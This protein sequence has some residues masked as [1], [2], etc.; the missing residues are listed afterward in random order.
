MWNTK[1][2][3]TVKGLAICCKFETINLSKTDKVLFTNAVS[4][5]K[6]AMSLPNSA[7]SFFQFHAKRCYN[8]AH[9]SPRQYLET[10]LF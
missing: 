9:L 6:V 1:E 3:V 7:I 5:K 8:I 2:K 10:N 4:S